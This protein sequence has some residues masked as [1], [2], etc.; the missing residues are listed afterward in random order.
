[1]PTLLPLLPLLSLYLIPLFP[2]K[3]R[4]PLTLPRAGTA[5]A[6]SASASSSN[7]GN[8]VILIGLI[9]QVITLSIFGLLALDVLLR[10]RKH[11]SYHLTTTKH[12]HSTTSTSLKNIII[13][14]GVAYVLILIR[15]VYRI[16]E[17][18]G[19][20]SN[21]VMQDQVLFVLLDGVMCVLAVM[22]LNV[23]HPGVL[24][25][26]SV[27]IGNAGGAESLEVPLV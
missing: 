22:V 17:M 15:C 1:M 13:A 9:T 19:G 12:I 2:P 21:K 25:E 8:T 23:W 18:A 10:I 7:T 11:S 27:A 3:P 20:W 4:P 26:Q 5:M 6:A 14:I 24:F 16:P